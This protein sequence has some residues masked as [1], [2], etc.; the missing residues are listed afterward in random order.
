MLKNNLLFC[1]QLHKSYKKT[2]LWAFCFSLSSVSAWQACANPLMPHDV[3]ERSAQHL[4]TILRAKEGI[5]RQEAAVLSAQGAFDP[6]LDGNHD[7]RGTGFY[8][9]R[10]SAL[11]LNQPIADFNTRVYAQY[12]ISGGDYP[13]YEGKFRT[14]D[15]GEIAVGAIFSLLRDRDIDSRRFAII[16]EELRLEES[17][18]ALELEQINA[19]L[20]AITSYWGWVSRGLEYGIRKDIWRLANNRQDA[21]TT[22]VNAGNKARIF[23][24]ENQQNMLKRKSA[25]RDAKRSWVSSAQ[26]LS[27]YHRDAEGAPLLPNDASL[28]KDF[29]LSWADMAWGAHQEYHHDEGIIHL[30]KDLITRRPDL[31][32]LD[33]LDR[34]FDQNRKLAKNQILPKL[35]LSTE[36]SQDVG[37]DQRIYEQTE[38]RVKLQLSIPL[39]TRQAEGRIRM[40]DA[41]KRMIALDR[42]RMNEQILIALRTIENDLSI[43]KQMMQIT[44]EEMQ[45][46]EALLQAERL[47]FEDGAS[48][49]FLLNLRE[50]TLAEA[51]VR[52]VKAVERYLVSMSRFVAA[53]MYKPALGL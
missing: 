35:D 46:A 50:E 15:G 48:D 2:L 53:S 41:D 43:G 1:G 11:R 31:R 13:S 12:G 10:Y 3:L 25:L 38:S 33:V 51:R 29:D 21:L 7:L 24:V 26:D 6:T 39:Q 40:A 19:Q 28:P 17:K 32:R 49:F 16:D 37:N 34:R 18:L 23:L 52:H 27:F 30:A 20:A 44:A 47:R 4:P 42:S 8:D 9:G 45:V 36:V 5:A 22:E 14:Q